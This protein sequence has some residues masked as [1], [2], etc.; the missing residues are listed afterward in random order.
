MRQNRGMGRREKPIEIVDEVAA[1]AVELRRLKAS[2]P[3]LTFRDLAARSHYSRTTLA[4]ATAGRRLPTLP[5]TL[6]IV[7]ACGGDPG[8]WRA[9]WEKARARQANAPTVLPA[10]PEQP[11]ADGSEPE[12]AGCGP[13]AAT[14]VA[15]KIARVDPRVNLGQIELRY[16]ARQRAA[17]G[18]FEGYGS[19][20]HLARQRR[21]EIQ[22][23]VA[24]ESDG[25]RTSVREPYC[26]DYHWC[27][28]L[29]LGG[30]RMSAAATVI[31]DGAPIAH[32]ST[33]W[34]TA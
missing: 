27:D 10:L 33:P 7:E 23:E 24:R 5:V 29:V 9:R 22:V 20:D 2:A 17:W 19:L 13:D 1:F 16:S 6:A 31:A 15:R 18:R 4:E 26:F 28:L 30:G 32:G 34:W 8:L 3:E 21:I 14:A 25:L 12:A 11:V